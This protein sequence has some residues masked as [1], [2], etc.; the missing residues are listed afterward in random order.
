MSGY[1]SVEHCD[2]L[3][4]AKGH[5][6]RHYMQV[7]RHGHLTLELERGGPKGCE[8]KGCDRIQ[9]SGGHCR[10]H[11]RQIKLYGALRPDREYMTGCTSCSEDGCNNKVRARGLCARHYTR[12]RRAGTLP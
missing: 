12:H 1:C 3:A 2:R 9:S 6:K 4:Y 5:C 11:A 10:K 7:L 8:A